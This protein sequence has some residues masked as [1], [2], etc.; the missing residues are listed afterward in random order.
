MVILENFT[1]DLNLDDEWPGGFW[2][3][4]TMWC[5]FGPYIDLGRMNDDYKHNIYHFYGPVDW[6]MAS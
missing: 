1:L 3:S 5:I 4:A 2:Y 6:L